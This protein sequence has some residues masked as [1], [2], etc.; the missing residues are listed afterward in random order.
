MGTYSYTANQKVGSSIGSIPSSIPRQQQ[1]QQMVAVNQQQN[2]SNGSQDNISSS[3]SSNGY[4]NQS[5]DNNGYGQQRYSANRGQYNQSHQVNHMFPKHLVQDNGSGYM[6][7]NGYGD[8]GYNTYNVVNNEDKQQQQ[9]QQH[10]D[11]QDKIFVRQH[12]H[13]GGR[14]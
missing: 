6:Q 7:Q 14:K 12:H 13:S 4:N 5:S 8:G 1:Q 3:S 10:S 11:E 2:N 9:Q